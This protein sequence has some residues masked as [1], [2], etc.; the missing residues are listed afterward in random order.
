MAKTILLYGRTNSG[1]TA[2]IGEFAEYVKQTT[3]KNT[4]LA[5]ADRGGLDTIRPYINL[6]IVEPIEIGDTDPWIFVRQVCEGKVRKDGKWVAGDNSN[7]GMFA[8]EGLRSF[9]ENFMAD[10]AK[11]SA[12]GINIGGGS[13]ISFQVSGDGESGKVSGGN[14]AHFGVAQSR[15]TEEVWSSF[16]LPADYILWTSSVSKDE[17]TTASGKVLGPDVI[18]K[19]L[20]AEVPRWFNFSFR[21]DVIPAQQGKPERHILYLGNHVD[22]GAGGAAGLGN[23]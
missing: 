18:G 1:K 23:I 14:V 10:M 7:I 11:K 9:A 2:Q 6:G 15:I 8:F 3:G 5:T 13:N 16:R 4:R 19:A 20:T 22:I 17:D 12:A 21:L